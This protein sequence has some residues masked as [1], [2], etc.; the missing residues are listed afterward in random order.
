MN[1]ILS[2][3]ILIKKKEN[4]MKITEFNKMVCEREGGEEEL[5]IA[6]IAEVIKIADELTNGILYKVI[7]V[8]PEQGEDA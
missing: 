4:N 6:Q 8:M 5:S 3:L 7:E 1:L 2:G